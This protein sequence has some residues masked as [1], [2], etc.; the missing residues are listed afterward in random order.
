MQNANTLI[1]HIYIPAWLNQV[2]RRARTPCPVG[3]VGGQM[4]KRAHLYCLMMMNND[5]DKRGHSPSLLGDQ[6]T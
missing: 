5:D 3:Y 4:Y 6:A 2:A 1:R